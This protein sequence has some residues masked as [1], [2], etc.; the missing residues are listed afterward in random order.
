[1]AEEGVVIVGAVDDE[2]IEGAALAGKA[3]VTAAYVGGYPGVRRVKLMK[4]RPRVGRSLTA[5][6]LTEDSTEERVASRMGVSEVT[7]T[8]VA[9]VPLSAG[10]AGLW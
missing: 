5:R 9:W 1:L 2:R 4:L 6:S 3:D 10:R 7:V 8:E